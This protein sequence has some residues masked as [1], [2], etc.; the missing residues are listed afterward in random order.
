MGKATKF[1]PEVKERAIRLVREQEGQYGSQWAAIK[2]G[3]GKI[4]CTAETLR[5][6]IG[7]SERERLRQL[8]IENK[9]LKRAKL[10]EQI[11]VPHIA[12]NPDSCPLPSPCLSPGDPW[13]VAG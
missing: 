7:Q 3:S 10:A 9:E 11:I 12:D 13:H 1:P 6:W 5:S 2:S 4:G 8:E